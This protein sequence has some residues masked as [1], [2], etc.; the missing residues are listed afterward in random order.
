MNMQTQERAL[1][2]LM[3][4]SISNTTN[5]KIRRWT[6]PPQSFAAQ[7]AYLHEHAYTPLTVT[8][9]IQAR[10]Q[11]VTRLPARS[12]VMTFDDAFADFLTAA[13]PVL[14]QYQFPATLYIP[15]AYVGKTSRW[16]YREGET[17]QRLLT[18]KQ[19]AEVSAN[20]IECGAHSHSHPQ[21]DTFSRADARREIVQSKQC[22]EEHLGQEVT[23][24]AYPFGYHSVTTRRL[25]R[26]AG[27]TSACAIRQTMSPATD[28]PFALAR[29]AIRPDITIEQFARLLD[30]LDEST[31]TTG[32]SIYTR[33]RSSVWRLVRCS[34]VAVN[35]RS[36]EK[37]LLRNEEHM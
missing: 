8:Q 26:E 10:S 29:L 4:H 30:G 18:W 28:D 2:I 31:Q 32:R 34:R 12:V 35:R 16:L 37:W 20:Q 25:V 9:L 1:P 6:V 14:T 17:D 22:L 36:Q 13:L 19:L 23:S 24:F 15:T 33:A 5:E 27:Y 3:Y 7:M 11:R 21:L